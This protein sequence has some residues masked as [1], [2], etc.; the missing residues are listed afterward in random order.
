VADLEQALAELGRHVEFP[1]TPD[2]VAA[3]RPHLTVRRRSPRRRRI[4]VLAFALLLVPVAVVAADEDARD[5]VLRFVGIRGASVER[6][7]ALPP[8]QPLAGPLQLG[9]RVSVAEA[10]RAAGFRVVLPAALGPPDAVYVRGQP[11]LARVSLVWNAGTRTA[12]TGVGLLVSELRG[13][14]SGDLLHKMAGMGTRLQQLRIG[15]EPALWIEGEPHEVFFRDGLGIPTADEGRLAGDTLLL[16]HGRLVVRFE[17][18]LG[19]AAVVRLARSL[20]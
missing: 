14:L 6:V 3:V 2:V 1:P 17:S 10:G 5:A 16:D 20:E 8:V 19:R 12:T 15:G 4:L 11:P 18:A 7:P 13:D 9:R